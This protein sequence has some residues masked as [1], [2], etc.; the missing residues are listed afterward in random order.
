MIAVWNAPARNYAHWHYDGLAALTMAREV[1]GALPRILAPSRMVPFQAASLGLLPWSAGSA[2][3]TRRGWSAAGPWSGHPP[4]AF[5]SPRRPR[6][7]APWR[8]YAPRCR[9]GAAGC[10]GIAHLC[11]PL[12]RARSRTI[13]NEEA[14]AEVLA[15]EGFEI[16]TPGSLPYADQVARFAQARVIMRARTAPA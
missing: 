8:R 1:L 9:R 11:G 15:A 10:R 12:R 3:S 14:V 5:R 16:V 13:D 4:W 6:P 7:G 2:W